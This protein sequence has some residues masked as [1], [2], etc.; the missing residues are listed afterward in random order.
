MRNYI[1]LGIG[2][3]VF[4]ILM[5]HVMNGCKCLAEG[6]TDGMGNEG[7]RG[8]GGG[9]GHEMGRHMANDHGM[10]GGHSGSGKGHMGGGHYGANRGNNNWLYGPPTV[11]RVSDWGYYPIY[12]Q[13]EYPVYY[14]NPNY[15]YEVSDPNGMFYYFYNPGLFFKRIFGY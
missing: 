1:I 3:V 12:T 4:I 7:S 2:I 8:H 9:G 5:G 13:Y 15:Y 10:V 11:G 6:F 14:T